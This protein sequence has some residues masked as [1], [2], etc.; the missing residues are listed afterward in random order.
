MAGDNLRSL[1]ATSAGKAQLS[2]WSEEALDNYLK[3]VKLT[4]FTPNTIVSKSALRQEIE[5]GRKRGW[6]LNNEESI[7]GVVTLSAPFQWNSAVYVITIAGPKARVEPKIEMA[8][9][10]LLEACRTLEMRSPQ[11]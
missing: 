6:L 11:K 7:E 10:Q 5:T 4:A 1:Y 2:S 9:Q 3:T 8:A